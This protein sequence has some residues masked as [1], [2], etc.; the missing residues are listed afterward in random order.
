MIENLHWLG[1]LKGDS[2]FT[3]ISEN[4]LKQIQHLLPREPKF[5]AN[6]ASAY[7]L[8]AYRSYDIVIVGKKAKNSKRVVESLF[9][10]YFYNGHSRRK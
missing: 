9:T 1:I 8:K 6:Y 10:Q 7:T 4:M 5:L 3:E 2:R